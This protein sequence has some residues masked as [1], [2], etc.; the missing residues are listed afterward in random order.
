MRFSLLPLEQ[1]ETIESFHSYNLPKT[2][3]DLDAFSQSKN[4]H[5]FINGK[6]AITYLMNK[7]NLKRE[8][9]VFISTTSGSNFVSTCVS[10]TIFNHCKISVKGW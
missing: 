10:A 8:D 3:F 9:G 6:A 1:I 5:Y 2:S 4:I 7:L